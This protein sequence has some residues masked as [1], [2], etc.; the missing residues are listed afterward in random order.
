MSTENKFTPLVVEGNTIYCLEEYDA[1]IKG[2]PQKRNKFC[3]QVSQYAYSDPNEIRAFTTLL[4]SAPDLL[5]AL[6]Y[7][8][9]EY[10]KCLFSSRGL[11]EGEIE[12]ELSAAK[13]AIAKAKGV[14]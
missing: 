14:L 10:E 4:A 1:F 11:N 3:A 5:A 7:V 8:T 2:I 12:E 13:K 9:K 6:E